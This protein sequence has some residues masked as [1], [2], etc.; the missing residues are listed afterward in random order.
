MG[1][2]EPLIVNDVAQPL[3]EQQRLTEIPA[4]TAFQ[5]R[6]Y[7]GV[8]IVLSSGRV[9]G[10]LC[11][12]DRTPQ[13][14]SQRDLDTLLIL[15]RLL[16]SQID[17]RDL[18][19]AEERQRLARE[20]HDTIAQSLSGLVL[21]LAYLA[22]SLRHRAPDQAVEILGLQDTARQALRE[23]RRS[24]WNLQPDVLEG[25]TL[26]EAIGALAKELSAAGVETSLELRGRAMELPAALDRALLRIAQEALT[27][28]RKH[29]G[30]R[31][32]LVSLEYFDDQLVLAVED[33][34]RGIDLSRVRGAQ[35]DSGFGLTS[36]RERARLAGGDVEFHTRSGGGTAV[37][38]ILPR[39][40]HPGESTTPR[41]TIASAAVKQPQV[42]VGLIDDHAIVRQGLRRLLESASDVTIVCEAADGGD[43][44]RVIEQD[45]PD[46]VLLDMQLPDMN[47]LH[48]LQHLAHSGSRARV[49]VLTTYA[50]DE[51]VFQAIQLG[52]RGYLL[53]DTSADDLMRAVRTV[54]SGA[55]MITPVAAERLAEHMQRREALTIREREVLDLLAAG[56]RNKEIAARLGMSEKTVQFHSANIFGKLGVQSRTEAVRVAIERGLILTS[57]AF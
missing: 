44:I 50:Q 38:C 28:V 54:A 5:M 27:N 7:I 3:Y 17:R 34:G 36:M 9:Y 40:G 8:P 39:T 51:V 31:S 15:A 48:V 46:V 33:D 42:R 13:Q 10:T 11:A 25:R 1:S 26:P 49:I 29:S 45:Q 12:L 21:D 57:N 22:G 6:A 32:A 18:A 16:A 35:A 2:V 41:N 23:L 56:L 30:A 20:I 52:A 24:I 53:K 4:V 43:A 47:G 19:I 37:V 14:K 55:T